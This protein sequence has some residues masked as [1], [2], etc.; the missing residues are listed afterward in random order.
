[1]IKIENTS[2]RFRLILKGKDCAPCILIK[3]EKIEIDPINAVSADLVI[4]ATPKLKLHTFNENGTAKSD[5]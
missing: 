1:M 3:G 4:Q 5:D 2:D